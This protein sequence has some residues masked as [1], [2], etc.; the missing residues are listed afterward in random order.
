MIVCLALLHPETL[1]DDEAAK[2]AS[3][4]L[5]VGT[6]AEDVRTVCAGEAD[7]QPRWGHDEKLMDKL[8]ALPE[9]CLDLTFQHALLRVGYGSRRANRSRSRTRST[10][11]S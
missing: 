8:R 7:W 6:I 1:G 5:T 9:W 10:A 2:A 3:A 4:R 11:T